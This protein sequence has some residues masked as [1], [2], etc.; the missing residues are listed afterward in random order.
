MDRASSTNEN[1]NA[2]S[3]LVRK[4]EEKIPLGRTRRRWVDNINIHIRD[5]G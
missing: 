1:R 3:I 4:P 5:T 2:Y